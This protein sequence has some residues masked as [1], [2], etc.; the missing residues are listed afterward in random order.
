MD[1]RRGRKQEVDAAHSS[2]RARIKSVMWEEPK[3]LSFGLRG[4]KMLSRRTKHHF[5]AHQKLQTDL[6]STR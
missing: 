2:I 3:R 1:R 6:H 5:H 4:R